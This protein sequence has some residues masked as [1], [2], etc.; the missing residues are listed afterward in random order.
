LSRLMAQ[1]IEVTREGESTGLDPVV[2]RCRVRIT[3]PAVKGLA[4]PDG[5]KGKEGEI[6]R[7]VLFDWE[8]VPEM[9]I[10]LS[11][12]ES[13]TFT[14]ASEASS[15]V[16]PSPPAP[17]PGGEGRDPGNGLKPIVSTHE[18]DVNGDGFAERAMENTFV[19][20]VVGPHVGAR[21]WEMHVRS[22]GVNLLAPT[23]A[24]T[25]DFVD[26]GGHHDGLGAERS[27]GE[28]WKAR[29]A[30][31]ER[32][33][34]DSHVSVDYRFASEAT[35]GLTV[36][37]RVEMIGDLPAIWQEIRFHYAGKPDDKDKKTEPDDEDKDELEVLYK[38]TTGFQYV[39]E[40]DSHVRVDIPLHDRVD[41]YRFYEHQWI[42]PVG[43][44]PLGAVAVQHE[45]L[46]VAMLI[47][48]RP[49]ALAT[50]D[51]GFDA[52]RLGIETRM[53]PEKLGPDRQL[54]RGLL[55]AAGAS[56]TVTP[57]LAALV[58][59]G[60]VVAGQRAVA[61]VA[62]HLEGTE[63]EVHLAGGALPLRS[64]DLPGVGPVLGAYGVRSADALSGELVVVIGEDTVALPLS[65]GETGAS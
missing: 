58:S 34:S 31:T 51:L 3:G 39:G 41:S 64:Y 19:R 20:A 7:R 35:K 17:L 24:L 43:G 32:A 53:F 27:P 37:K 14:A 56:A 26:L 1:I 61:V 8:L 23:H 28:L 55:W 60:E 40:M 50:V 6:T 29:F 42:Y 15:T 9:K 54:T 47:L 63:G 46:G 4:I 11:V 49:G 62:R 33:E 44:V 48:T 57:R 59:L 38:P 2:A 21:I 16:T 5:V 30:E 45:R 13:R 52:R 12:E 10:L 65:G 25:K 18:A 22:A 36:S